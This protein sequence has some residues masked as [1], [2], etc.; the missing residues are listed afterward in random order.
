MQDDDTTPQ[1]E[2]QFPQPTAESKTSAPVKKKRKKPTLNERFTA[3]A[4]T[5]LYSVDNMRLAWEDYNTALE[6]LRDVRGE[7]ER[8][9][10]DLPEDLQSSPLAEKLK[11]ISYINLDREIQE[12][13]FDTLESA[14][15]ECLDAD[16]PEESNQKTRAPMP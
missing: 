11:D 16:L 2:L 9:W 14:A 7:Y 6:E 12:P 8:L 15:Q 10:D 5:L 13:D 4:Q 3:A 1:P